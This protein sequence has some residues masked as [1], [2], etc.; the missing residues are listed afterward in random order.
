MRLFRSHIQSR[1]LIKL[2]QVFFLFFFS[3]LS[4]SILFAELT[5]IVLFDF[6][7]GISPL[8]NGMQVW[9]E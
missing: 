6:F 4:F 7:K 5:F 2:T 1:G 3:I 9:H 8:I